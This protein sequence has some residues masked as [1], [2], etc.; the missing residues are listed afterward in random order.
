VRVGR[1]SR[2]KS[3]K[4]FASITALLKDNLTDVQVLKYGPAGSD[5]KLSS[6]N[7]LSAYLVVGKSKDGKAAGVLIGSVET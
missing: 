7:G 1:R 6:D 2:A 3:G 5:G 4:A